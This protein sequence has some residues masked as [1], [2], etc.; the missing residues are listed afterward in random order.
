VSSWSGKRN[1]QCPSVTMWNIMLPAM[2]GISTPQGA[3]NSE[4][5]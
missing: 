3:L 5:A 1:Q 4:L 2:G